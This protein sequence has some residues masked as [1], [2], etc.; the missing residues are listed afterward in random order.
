M[1]TRIDRFHALSRLWLMLILII[2]PALAIAK[3][4]SINLNKDGIAI[5]GYD[6]VAY[7]VAGKAK[8]GKRSLAYQWLGANWLFSSA[9]NR[10]AF[11]DN[12][13]QYLPEFGGFC[14]Y[15][16]S[17]GQLAD[18]DPQAWSIVNG[19]LYLNFSLRV[20]EIWRPRAE[21]FMGDAKL[22]W[23]TMGLPEN[24]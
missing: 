8:P 3:N 9:L 21:E 6:P 4:N 18:I 11:I 7:F 19:R 17:V 12:P 24:K 14:A 13:Q 2:M 16:A 1:E 15:A 22:L 23:P 20:R 10:Q 5:H